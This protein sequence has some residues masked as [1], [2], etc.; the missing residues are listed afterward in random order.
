M[1]SS[2]IFSRTFFLAIEYIT[3]AMEAYT[4]A[5]N[6]RLSPAHSV[7][8][9]LALSFSVFYYEIKNEP[10]KARELAKKVTD[11]KYCSDKLTLCCL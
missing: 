8:L 11:C 4:K 3:K 1:I 5:Q 7:Q 6:N 9:G 10:D 2:G